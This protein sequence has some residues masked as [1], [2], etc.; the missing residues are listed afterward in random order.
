[1]KVHDTLLLSTISV[2]NRYDWLTNNHIRCMDTY[3]SASPDL[4]AIESVWT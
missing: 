4:D 2:I 3:P 1:M